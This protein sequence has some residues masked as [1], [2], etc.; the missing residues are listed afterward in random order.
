MLIGKN[1]EYYLKRTRAAAKENELDVP[2]ELRARRDID[3]QELFPTAIACIADLSADIVRGVVKKDIVSDVKSQLYFA[4]KFFDSFLEISSI[5]KEDEFLLLIGSAAYYLC[6]QIGSSNVL[7]SKLD[8]SWFDESNGKLEVLLGLLLQNVA[9]IEVVVSNDNEYSEYIAEFSTEYLSVINQG[10]DLNTEWIQK[11]RHYVYDIGSD[12]DVLLIDCLLAIFILKSK[13]SIFK[14]LPENSSL[15]KEIL[16]PIVSVGNF[17]RELWPA[18]RYMC[19]LGLF[20]GKSGV[21]QMPT[22]A[23]KTKSIS[24]AIFS[25]FNSEKTKLSIVVA[26][27]RALCRE[28]SRDLERDF[29]FDK[30]IHI[31]EL[32]DLMQID[33]ILEDILS[34]T[35]K[36]I[37]I[38]TPEKLMFL[39]RQDNNILSNAG[40]IIFDEGHLFDDESRG[41]NYE[42]LIA[43][44]LGGIKSSAQ[45]ILISAIIPN[46]AE[47]NKWFTQGEGVSFNGQDIA[48]VEKLPAILNWEKSNGKEFCYLYYL[49]KNDLDNIDFFVPRIIELIELKKMPGERKTRYF[50]DV[51][52]GKHVCKTKNDVA[53]AC[54]FRLI[55]AANS[56]IFCGT[57]TSANKILKRIIELD[58]RAYDVEKLMSRADPD[59][60]KCITYLISKNYGEDSIY[61][62]AAALGAFVHHRGISDGIKVAVEYALR[63]SKITNVICTSTLAQGVNLPI[64]YLIV[65]NIYQGREKISV[66]DFHNLIGRTGRSGMFT[67]GT[68]V[69][70][71][72]FAYNHKK[73]HWKWEQ[74]KQLFDGKN[75]EDCYS[76][77][78]YLCCN[79]YFGEQKYNFYEPILK[80][81]NDRENLEKRIANIIEKKKENGE[82]EESEFL[83][84][85]WIYILSILGSIES[86]VAQYSIESEEY[87]WPA[88]LQSILE[89]T[90]AYALVTDEEKEKLRIIVD[91]IHTYII[92]RFP[93]S[94]DR[95][96]FSQSLL[97]S[98]KFISLQ[99]NVKNNINILD[100]SE[101]EL[102]IWLINLIEEYA[103]IKI[104]KKI[105]DKESIYL[106][107]E[108]WIN[109]LSY[110]EVLESVKKGGCTIFR[111]GKQQDVQME[112]IV[113]ICDN[114]FGYSA[115]LIINGVCG[116]LMDE[117]EEIVKLVDK[118]QYIGKMLKYGTRNQTSIFIY[119]VGFNDRFLANEI[120]NII[121][122]KLN[123]KD[124]I[125]AIKYLNNSIAELLKEYP[126]VFRYRL[127]QIM[128]P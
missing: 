70:S 78:M 100:Y 121:G 19:D 39:L 108:L 56:A 101:K 10:N 8:I 63:N 35:A 115:T 48:T 127:Q 76:R 5:D 2:N 90:L 15:T 66:R 51:D 58:E 116:I 20:N 31:R 88:L 59:E 50:P 49:D 102:V 73:N 44:I 34:P 104:M 14:M 29:K 98:T 55:G 24:L 92:S 43:T 57:K 12:R 122:D 3:I 120:K 128:H 26:P 46:A 60:I 114:E 125:K 80:Y 107:A 110:F 37:V 28:I 105:D 54:L 112:D 64:K 23:G 38:T 45:K 106:I 61:Y 42:L 62:K 18:Q 25:E 32:S 53:L 16:I 74:Y 96:V 117:N 71:D 72:S 89:N 41:A 83:N 103:D 47:I 22:G 94:L 11:F 82:H 33:Y 85:T 99:E 79:L 7:A 77:L 91:T 21:I 1:A 9:N 97:S 36:T 75:S 68:I 30:D 17:M 93:I 52:F 69:F 27:F 81:Y 67:E 124:V 87:E 65:S 123:K 126:S 118:M 113:E 84:E 109:G 40:Q 95:R 119:E 86:F 6:D 4:S 111:Y 13:Y